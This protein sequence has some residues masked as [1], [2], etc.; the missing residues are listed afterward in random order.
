MA[1]PIALIALLVLLFALTF[2]LVLL[3]NYFQPKLFPNKPIHIAW[4]WIIILPILIMTLLIVF[5]T[6]NDEIF[7]HT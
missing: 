3:F 6:T 4:Y 5:L 1:L 2:V 7:K